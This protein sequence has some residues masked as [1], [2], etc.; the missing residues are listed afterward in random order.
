[1]AIAASFLV[2][3]GLGLQKVSLCDPANARL[4][5]WMQPKWILGFAALLIGNIIDFLAFGLAP[6]SLLAPLG[7]LSLV[8]NL[9][10]SS[11]MLNEKYDRNDVLAVSLI[12]FGT[13]VTVLYS[14]HH[15]RVYSLE[16]LRDLYHK[17][18]MMTYFIIVP[19]LLAAH[20]YVIRYVEDKNMQGPIWRLAELIAW[21][22]FAGITGGQSVLFAK[23]TVELLK[24]AARG[25]DV[26][27][28]LDTYVIIC[29]LIG[30]LL[31]QITFLNGAMKRFDQL[32]VMPVYQSYWI[33]SGVIGG[34]VYFG[35]WEEFTQFQINM[36]TIG[37]IITLLGLYVLTKKENHSLERNQIHG[38]D[39]LPSR[40]ISIDSFASE[41]GQLEE[42]DEARQGRIVDIELPS[43]RASS[44]RRSAARIP[45]GVTNVFDLD[46][47]RRGSSQSIAIT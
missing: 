39:V 25:D 2:C 44:P 12:F 22:G 1:M 46:T 23:S 32:Y 40:R 18:R 29:A 31:T 15:E 42:N 43:R 34:L 11:Y 37:T 35:E 41:I 3:L 45:S 38:F 7:A 5:P 47:R 20:Y 36:F 16:T 28:H 21:C 30:C 4:S 27:F 33:I 10:M 19:S 13:T 24:D 14:N 8:W 9:F 17:G 26:F 6:A